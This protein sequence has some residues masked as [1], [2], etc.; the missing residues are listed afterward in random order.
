VALTAGT[1]WPFYVRADVNVIMAFISATE[2]GAK[3]SSVSVR[4]VNDTKKKFLTLTL[5]AYS[6][7][8]L[9][10]TQNKFDYLKNTPRWA[11][12]SRPA[13]HRVKWE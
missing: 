3:L 8:D 13:A 11:C 2:Y 10:Q 6:I 7:N 12:L 5:I 9:W 1:G 4:D